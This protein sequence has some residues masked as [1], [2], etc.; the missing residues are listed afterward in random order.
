VINYGNSQVGIDFEYTG[1]P[2]GWP[3]ISFA[4]EHLTLMSN[5]M[6]T[7]EV[8]LTAPTGIQAGDSKAFLVI[9]K[10]TTSTGVVE[11]S[12]TLVAKIGYIGG[13]NVSIERA[14]NSSL[15]GK[16]VC[17]TIS[18]ENIGN[19][20]D[21]V[22][23]S[24]YQL[25]QNWKTPK[26]LLDN[27]SITSFELRFKEL[28]D[29]ILE[30][31]IPEN[32]LAG[33][34]LVGINV[35]ATGMHSTSIL[36]VIVNVTQVFDGVLE[37]FDDVQNQ[38]T[39]TLTRSILFGG[40]KLI[41][42]RLKNPGNG[43]DT[44]NLNIKDL[45]PAWVGYMASVSN[46]DG[47]TPNIITK[48]FSGILDLHGTPKMYSR[49]G[50]QELSSVNLVMY[51]GDVLWVSIYVKTSSNAESEDFSVSL[52]SQGGTDETPIDNLVAITLNVKFAD[53][54][55]TDELKHS[56]AN[57]GE[58]MSIMAHVRNKGDI[59]VRDVMVT[60]YI[61]GTPV[62]SQ[63]LGVLQPSGAQGST[64]KVVS[65]SW[66]ADEGTHNLK[67]VVDDDKS[68]TELDEN[69]NEI[70][71]KVKVSVSFMSTILS[72][73]FVIPLIMIIVVI[74]IIIGLLLILKK[75]GRFKEPE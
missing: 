23:L 58:L 28:K 7:T 12:I 39:Y 3:V 16:K 5:A 55:F 56:S 46:I 61:D 1:L 47:Y 73:K 68:I 34:H 53:L 19:G 42:L 43:V 67:L 60:L 17:Y 20:D 45:G 40:N 22:E 51:P 49:V 35:S 14:E 63:T 13:I 44:F 8:T 31:E 11:A 70:S 62:K 37:V 71:T 4:P 69:N 24:P 66:Q 54:E 27:E 64:D 50:D 10:G 57:A 33:N 48:D 75:R 6:D 74:L 9:A 52:T 26:F 41:T 25:D 15:P 36:F 18:V 2:V 72:N 38:Y 29:I 59:E 65:F 32:A 30:V 21:T